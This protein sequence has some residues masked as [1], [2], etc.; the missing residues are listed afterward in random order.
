M[1]K[2]AW[3]V[4]SFASVLAAGCGAVEESEPADVSAASVSAALAVDE[5]DMAV[6]AAAQKILP[7]EAEH[8][9]FDTPSS[10]YID[11]TTP[12]GYR[13]FTA[14]AGH[15]FK[16]GAFE[17]DGMGGHVASQ[18]VD[19]KLQR[20]VKKS[21]R[22]EWQVVAYGQHQGGSGAAVVKYKP[23]ASSG[24]GLYLITAVAKNHPAAI[25]LSIG[26]FGGKGCATAQQ[27]GESCG[28]HTRDP[29][30]CDEGL[31]CNYKPGEGMCGY[32]D[33]PGTCA[34]RPRLCPLNYSPVCGCD[35]KTYSNLCAAG[36]AGQG[37]LR[38]GR[39]EVEVEGAWTQKLPS[40]AVVDYTFNADGTFTST[41]RPACL[42]STPPCA[43][44]IA[45]GEGT[46]SI[47]DWTVSLSYTSPSFHTPKDTSFEFSLVRRVPH[48]RGKDYGQT[49][50]LTRVP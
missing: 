18:V 38:K 23:P 20:A 40:G 14:K 10:A 24:E 22:W 46:Y 39:C 25:T 4:F 37:V 29:N 16:T 8:I 34:I 47:F 31:F 44:K 42:F 33:A 48:M 45:L 35:G 1:T 17:N 6:P 26:C 21:G 41:E 19:F 30:V 43:V 49:L 28:G 36:A 3:I 50:D 15:E 12:Y 27:P 32:A 7:A 13:F 5:T 2:N 9:Y 11:D